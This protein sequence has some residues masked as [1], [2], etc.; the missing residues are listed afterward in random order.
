MRKTSQIRNSHRAMNKYLKY[1]IILLISLIICIPNALANCKISNIDIAKVNNITY[2]TIYADSAIDFEHNIILE[3][4]IR[5]V[6]DLKNCE[7]DLP[8]KDYFS[9]PSATIK[10]I[11]TSQFS[12]APMITRL[13]FDIGKPITYTVR[14]AGDK[15]II[16]FP[17]PNDP[18]FEPWAAV[19]PELDE[20]PESAADLATDVEEED[21]IKRVV[22]RSGKPAQPDTQK[23]SPKKVVRKVVRRD[24]PEPEPK[25][26]KEKGKVIETKH[27]R[28]NVVYRSRG[29]RDPFAS[30]AVT[31]KGS[32]AFGVLPLPTVEELTFV[33]VLESNG[34]NIALCE[35]AE[36]NAYILKAGDKI[37]GGWV[38]RVTDDDIVFAI[39]EFGWTRTVTLNLQ[40][41]I[42]K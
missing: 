8:Q 37:K 20:E 35:D 39:S 13:V 12:L 11:R 41:I 26:I 19:E 38:S 5:L 33:G 22:R 10:S 31:G 23:K 1:T 9:L 40:D 2:T 28:K 4:P 7:H 18:D 14:D 15:L 29:T 30:L 42:D 24:E 6:V 16:S 34:K 17:T 36:G 27:E 25:E 21:G 3:E 32:R